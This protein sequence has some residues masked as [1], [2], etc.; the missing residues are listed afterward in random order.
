[1]SSS[2]LRIIAAAAVLTAGLA[3]PAR[4][5]FI[6]WFESDPLSGSGPNVFFAE[7][8][9]VARFVHIDGERPRFPG[10]RRGTLRVLYDTTAPQARIAAPIGR[11]LSLGDDFEFGAILS[12]RSEGFFASP[13][14]FS[15]I[16]FGLWNSAT[17][18]SNRTGFPSDAFDLVEFDYFA[19]AGPFGGPFLS[20][21]IFGGDAGGNAFLNFTFLSSEVVLPHDVPLL[22][23]LVY[24]AAERRLTVSVAAHTGGVRFQEIPGARVVV[25]LGVLNPTFLVDSIGI[26]A[27]FEGFESLRAEVDFDLLYV[28][29][30]PAPLAPR[31]RRFAR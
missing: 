14:G 1:M 29:D 30:L 11:V 21:S 7:G 31:R 28:D 2:A 12:I 15:Q 27:Y 20:P 25:D 13:D 3:A 24:R 17:T 26:A 23:R 10:D 16:A 9:A 8:D 19:N 4:A 5:G 18:G 22:C 6:D